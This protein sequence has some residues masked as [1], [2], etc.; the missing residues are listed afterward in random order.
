LRTPDI[1]RAVIDIE[2]AVRAARPD[3][4]ALFVKPQTC[5]TYEAIVRAGHGPHAAPP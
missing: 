4:V 5:K 2:R 1:E 3:V